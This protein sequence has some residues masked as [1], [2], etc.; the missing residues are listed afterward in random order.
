MTTARG[1]IITFRYSPSSDGTEVRKFLSLA[2]SPLDDTATQGN[3]QVRR[4]RRQDHSVFTQHALSRRTHHLIE[5]SR[6][7]QRRFAR[8]R[9]V[10]HAAAVLKTPCP[11]EPPTLQAI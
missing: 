6:V 3:C 2:Q 11:Q 8:G 4:P 9:E 10:E 7:L 1:K 5:R